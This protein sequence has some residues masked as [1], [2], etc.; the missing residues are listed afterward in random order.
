MKARALSLCFSREEGGGE[1]EEAPA[2]RRRTPRNQLLRA[3]E[4]R[5]IVDGAVGVG[6]GRNEERE[7]EEKGRID[8]LRYEVGNAEGLG[9]LI[10]VGGAEIFLLH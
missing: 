8:A 3:G 1:R 2:S 5:S 10:I 4:V 9:A 6:V 7:R